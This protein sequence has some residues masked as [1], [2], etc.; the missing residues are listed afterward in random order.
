MNE[1]KTPI[2]FFFNMHIFFPILLPRF[3]RAFHP[4]AEICRISLML[5]K[6]N[7]KKRCFVSNWRQNADVFD[8]MLSGNP[9]SNSDTCSVPSC[10]SSHCG[11]ESDSVKHSHFIY[12]WHQVGMLAAHLLIFKSLSEKAAVSCLTPQVRN[13]KR[14][15]QAAAFFLFFFLHSVFLCENSICSKFNRND[16]SFT[17]KW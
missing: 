15:Q 11:G 13:L 12:L 1:F 5:E 7:K 14:R 3:R 10:Q 9:E 4:K 8:S 2:S 6:K 17:L 16:L